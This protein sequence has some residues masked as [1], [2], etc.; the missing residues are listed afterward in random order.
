MPGGGFLIIVTR[1]AGEMVTSTINRIG[2]PVSLDG[3]GQRHPA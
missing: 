2:R 3:L 1:E